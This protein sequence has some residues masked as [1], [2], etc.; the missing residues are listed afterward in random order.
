ML[1]NKGMLAR[2]KEIVEKQ[3]DKTPVSAG[4]QANRDRFWPG[5]DKAYKG[6]APPL[7]QCDKCDSHKAVNQL[8][9]NWAKVKKII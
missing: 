5:L 1:F 7:K 9:E 3:K 8:K 4:E 6:W 2:A